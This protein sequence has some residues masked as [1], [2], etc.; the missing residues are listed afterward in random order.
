MHQRSVRQQLRRLQWRVGALYSGLGTATA[1]L[2][3]FSAD[4]AHL[5]Q[6]VAAA[7]QGV[8]HLTD[9][10]HNIQQHLAAGQL[11]QGQG[12]QA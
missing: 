12:Q 9:T 11:Q 7:R 10:V 6:G 2:Q 3:L 8:V 4:V 1:Q 5:Q